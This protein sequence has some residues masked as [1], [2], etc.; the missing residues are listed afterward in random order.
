MS[1]KINL[2]FN[3]NCSFPIGE[4]EKL[5]WDK[6]SKDRE[7]KIKNKVRVK[8]RGRDKLTKK[9]D[10]ILGQHIKFDDD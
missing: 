1:I 2:K 4:E 7:N 3:V 6:V 5:Y 10:R 8:Q 9:A